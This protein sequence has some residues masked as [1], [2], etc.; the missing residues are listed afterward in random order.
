MLIVPFR[1]NVNKRNLK[2]AWDVHTVLHWPLLGGSG[3]C[4]AV[5]L[6]TF[7]ESKDDAGRHGG[8]LFLI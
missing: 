1:T 3:N 5:C 8:F 6:L 4:N 7:Y 2:V